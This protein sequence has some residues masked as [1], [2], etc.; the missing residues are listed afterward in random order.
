MHRIADDCGDMMPHRNEVHLPFYLKQELFSV[1]QGE[2]SQLYP[3]KTVPTKRYFRSIWKAKC[4]HIKVIK[5]KRFTSCDTCDQ[6]RTLLH[7]KILDGQSTAKFI[8]NRKNHLDFVSN[9]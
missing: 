3:K 6:L 8:E 9:E 1:F 2:L 4:S 5:A 7:N